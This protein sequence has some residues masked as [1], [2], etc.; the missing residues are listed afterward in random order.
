MK[1]PRYTH[2]SILHNYHIYV[3]GGRFFGEDQQAILHGCEKY[4]FSDNEWKSLPN[5]NVK[6]CTCYVIEWKKDLFVFGG[7]TGTF[8][9]SEKI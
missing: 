3:I 6:R 5:L 7:Y 1:Q 2:A 9:R 4:S 8:E